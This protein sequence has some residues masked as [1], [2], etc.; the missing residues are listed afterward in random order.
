MIFL[1]NER[2]TIRRTLTTRGRN[3]QIGPRETRSAPPVYNQR[4]AITS[5]DLGAPAPLTAE[6]QAW[7]QRS[8]ALWQRAHAIVHA[9]PALDAGDVYHA[10][11][12]LE[13]SPEE[14][15]RRGLGRGRLRAHA[16]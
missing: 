16:R 7:A 5:D 2:R 4:V 14:R 8:E 9:H 6:Q 15:L 11:R 10:L 13:L 3:P 1:K 12:C